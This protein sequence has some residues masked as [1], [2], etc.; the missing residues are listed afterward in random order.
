MSFQGNPDKRSLS[1][2]FENLQEVAKEQERCGTPPPHGNLGDKYLSFGAARPPLPP[3]GV[4]GQRLPPT[5]SSPPSIFAALIDSA[6]AT[7]RSL[8]LPQPPSMSQG[9]VLSFSN[10]GSLEGC[11]L[12]TSISL[13]V[14]ESAGLIAARQAQ[15][16][17]GRDKDTLRKQAM[18]SAKLVELRSLDLLGTTVG[19]GK[20]TRGTPM[21]ANRPNG[22]AVSLS[23]STSNGS[24]GTLAAAAVESVPVAV[25][26][27]TGAVPAPAPAASG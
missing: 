9:Q 16:V 20:N 7:S 22:S 25:S 23:S 10:E 8:P 6:N 17:A 18:D 13:P 19:N 1:K 21:A 11:P 5:R 4:N 3:Y 12:G 14:G 15:K 2:L 26:T 27:T 24:N